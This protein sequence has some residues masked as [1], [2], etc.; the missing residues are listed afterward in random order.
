[1]GAVD[2]GVVV[3]QHRSQ[4]RSGEDRAELEGELV[5]V[6]VG[7]DLG[8][9]LRLP[10]RLGEE[11]TPLTLVL[12]HAVAHRPAT[13]AH[14]G[15]HADE[16]AAAREDP[17]L[18]VVEVAVAEA[19][20]PSRPGGV[21]EMTGAITWVIRLERAVSIVSSWSCSFEPKSA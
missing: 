15:G 20:Q 14:V 6:G 18:D 11:I 3:V 17:L 4:V 2:D 16:E 21:P 1:M 5:G 9:G 8:G 10:G 13:A 12:G 19:L 7:V